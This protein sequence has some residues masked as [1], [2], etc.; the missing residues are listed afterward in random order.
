MK[1]I[2]KEIKLTVEIIICQTW[3]EMKRKK[4]S[5]SYY[6]KSRN[7]LNYLTDRIEERENDC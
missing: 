2:K 4:Y 1:I 7:L 6:H 3:V 5:K